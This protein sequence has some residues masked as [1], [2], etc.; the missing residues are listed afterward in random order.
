MVASTLD[1]NHFSEPLHQNI[2]HLLAEHIRLGKQASATVLMPLVAQWPD[3][4]KGK[5]AG[6]YLL[7]INQAGYDPAN[8]SDLATHILELAQR[9]AVIAECKVASEAAIELADTV[10]PDGIIADLVT[11]L[12]AIADH[13][14]KSEFSTAAEAGQRVIDAMVRAETTGTPPGLQYGFSNIARYVPTL[15][16]GRLYVIAGRPSMGKTALALNIAEKVADKGK[17][18]HVISLEMSA[19][20]LSARAI[21]GWSGVPTE[22]IQAG[23]ANENQ[24][25]L[26]MKAHERWAGLPVTIDDKSNGLPIAQIAARVRQMRRKHGIELLV[27]DYLQL[28]RGGEKHR[29]NRVQEISEITTGLKALA[30]DLGIPIIALSQLSRGVESRDDKRPLLSDLRDSGSI[31]QDADAVAFVYREEYYVERQK[32]DVGDLDKMEAWRADMDRVANRAEV[33]V[34]KQRNGKI[35][36]AN[37]FFDG[38]RTRFTDLEP[39]RREVAS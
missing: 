30:M 19:D 2:W 1:E 12:D 8:L 29:G 22:I 10:S 28:I 27:V 18:V 17:A 11:S 34:A 21:A 38:A 9:R 3:I 6:Q 25:S 31:E 35:G 32:P 37:L 39:S 24:R 23:T 7:D 15:M 13:A 5:T 14:S 36:T 16:P 26:I 20:E 4:R 33:I